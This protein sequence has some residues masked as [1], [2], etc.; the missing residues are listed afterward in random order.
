MITE[1]VAECWDAKYDEEMEILLVFVYIREKG[2]K[3]VLPLR[4]A[5]LTFKGSPN[6]PHEEM[7]KTAEMWKGHPFNLQ[8]VDDEQKEEGE[9]LFK[10]EKCMLG[11][12]GSEMMNIAE[13]MS[14]DEWIMKFKKDHLF[15]KKER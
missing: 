14:S 9:E 10:N 7:Y 4:R 5:D 1:M 13:K 11:E 2:V 6:P 8:I 12:V 3:R 15:R